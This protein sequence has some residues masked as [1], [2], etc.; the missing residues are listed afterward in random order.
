MKHQGGGATLR[1]INIKI[2]N[3]DTSTLTDLFV[4]D[5]ND[6]QNLYQQD[7]FE[8]IRFTMD[9]S[10]PNFKT[11]NPP[12]VYKTVYADTDWSVFH[13]T[14]PEKLRFYFINDNGSTGVINNL[15]FFIKTKN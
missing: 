2:D 13:D 4:V 1:V 6:L 7:E 15:K 5:S 12:L 3:G 10:Y 9:S 8:N 14:R 11:E